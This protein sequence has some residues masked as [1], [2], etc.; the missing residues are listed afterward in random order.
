MRE[1]QAPAINSALM[2]L[3]HIAKR[4]L[5]TREAEEQA[6][7]PAPISCRKPYFSS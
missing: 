6:A 5:A 3:R 2:L 7:N 4:H 1:P